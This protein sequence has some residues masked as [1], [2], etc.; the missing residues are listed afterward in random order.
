MSRGHGDATTDCCTSLLSQVAINNYC[1]DGEGAEVTCDA[2]RG[3]VL[4][5]FDYCD[6]DDDDKSD[7]LIYSWLVCVE[8]AVI[9][10]TVPPLFTKWTFTELLGNIH[11]GPLG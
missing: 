7:S 6:D 3:G 2:A 10:A 9:L 11:V 4:L 1:I 8:V 5:L